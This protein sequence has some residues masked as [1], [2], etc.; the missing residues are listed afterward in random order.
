MCFKLL[1]SSAIHRKTRADCVTAKPSRDEKSI[2]KFC[3]RIFHF[4]RNE[5]K[6]FFY[7]KNFL[8]FC[9]HRKRFSC[10]QQTP[11]NLWRFSSRLFHLLFLDMRSINSREMI[12]PESKLDRLFKSQS[13]IAGEKSLLTPKQTRVVPILFIKFVVFSR[14]NERRSESDWNVNRE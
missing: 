10:S 9:I 8:T 14:L 6:F 5:K 4:E 1:E 3:V 12:T 13:T 11:G 7:R 2:Y